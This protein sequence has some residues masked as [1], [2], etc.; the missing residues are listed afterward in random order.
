MFF[1][2]Y[3]LL[4]ISMKRSVDSKLNEILPKKSQNCHDNEWK[5]FLQYYKDNLF[6]EECFVQY[7]DHLRNEKNYAPNIQ[8]IINF[9]LAS[10]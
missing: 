2:I 10:S 6:T 1:E 8:L 3:I 9:K 7:F 5:L 4:I